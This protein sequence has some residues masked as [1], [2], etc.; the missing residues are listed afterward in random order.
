MFKGRVMAQVVSRRPL[1]AEVR[2]RSQVSL[3]EI[4]GGKSGTGKGFSPSISLA[5]I[6]PMLHTHLHL[7]IAFAWRTNGRGPG[8]LS[9]SNALSENRRKLDTKLLPFLKGWITTSTNCFL[10][11]GN[12]PTWRTNYFQCIYLFIVLYMFRACHAHHQGETDCINTASG[13]C[14]SVL[15]AV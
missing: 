8:N 3:Y 15:V 9:K 6:P 11:L 7:N 10:I 5:S 14:H 2:F 13:N 12:C 4:C 1:T